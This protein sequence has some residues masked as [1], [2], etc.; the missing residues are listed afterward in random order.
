MSELP[1]EHPLVQNDAGTEFVISEVS[2]EQPAGL[3]LPADCCYSFSQ[4]TIR[5]SLMNYYFE[6]GNKCPKPGVIFLSKRGQ[7]ICTKLSDPGVQDCM[8]RLTPY[9]VSQI[10]EP[11]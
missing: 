3:T 6:T 9:P 8:R 2:L 10:R 4:Q 5:C 1:L 11:K 7:Q